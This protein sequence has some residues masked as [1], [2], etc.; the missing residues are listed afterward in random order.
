MSVPACAARRAHA[1]EAAAACAP[2]ALGARLR[3]FWDS[4]AVAAE[5]A[6]CPALRLL[7]VERS[8]S[9]L[10]RHERGPARGADSRPLPSP[11]WPPF[12]QALRAGGCLATVRPAP[13]FN[14]G[15]AMYAVDLDVDI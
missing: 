3:H 1:G 14:R 15:H 9:S 10:W 4:P 12:A 5:L 2:A 8:Y 7:E 6:R 13:I 11:L